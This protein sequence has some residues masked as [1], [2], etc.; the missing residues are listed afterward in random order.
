MQIRMGGYLPLS[1]VSTQA[2]HHV[3]AS[4]RRHGGADLSISFEENVT[5]SG[6]M[7]ID[8]VTMV[9]TGKMDICYFA[10]SYLA[11]RIP[12]LRQFDLPFPEA[13]HADMLAGLD[14][15]HGGVLAD[16]VAASTNLRV[17]AYWDDG[18][19]HISNAR[20]PIRTPQ[21][22]RGLKLRTVDN[23]F[24][25]DVFRAI[26]FDPIRIDVADLQAAV[27]LGVVDAQE[28]PLTNLVNLG[29]HRHHRHVSLTGHFFGVLCVLVNRNRFDSWPA[30]IRRLVT[31]AIAEAT[32]IQRQLARN[33]DE[34]C[35]AILQ[36]AGCR[37]IPREELDIDAFKAAA[38]L[39][40]SAIAPAS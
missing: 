32:G 29:L 13:S 36:N 7:A 15:E 2:M 9:E 4:L 16:D 35:L 20:H 37:I 12:A 30:E 34:R 3:A 28:N 10:T 21:D 33:E 1:S 11:R 38:R 22:C 6:R 31:H 39:A 5:L 14:G 23:E 25:Q 27:E 17:L 26:G 19:R 18:M 8:L 24:H 40:Y